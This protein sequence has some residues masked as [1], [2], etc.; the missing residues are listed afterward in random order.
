MLDEQVNIDLL[1]MIR[2]F[3]SFM[4]S[5]FICGV[6]IF[7]CYDVLY[8]QILLELQVYALSEPMGC[9]VDGK[10]DELTLQQANITGFSGDDLMMS[11]GSHADVNSDFLSN[12]SKG[13]GSL[14]LTGLENLGN[15][16]FM[17][18][19]IQCL[20]HTPKLVDYFLGD[21]NREINPHN[22]LGMNVS[23]IVSLSLSVSEI[24]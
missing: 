20:A 13:V 10:K 22:P 18:S 14:G 2:V 3:T 16:C 1:Y 21:Y 17:N 6:Y 12:S 15:T 24:F 19:A 5:N 4:I 7:N 9:K 11:N 8:V 23:Y